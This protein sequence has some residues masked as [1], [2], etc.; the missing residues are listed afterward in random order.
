MW[1]AKPKDVPAATKTTAPAN[2]GSSF[3]LNGTSQY[4]ETGSDFG[5]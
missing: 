5:R 2:A 4:F 1:S 3:Q